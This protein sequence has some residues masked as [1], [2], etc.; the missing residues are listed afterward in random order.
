LLHEKA[1]KKILQAYA[2]W[3]KG[4]KIS[5]EDYLRR[6]RE[7]SLTGAWAKEVADYLISKEERKHVK[8]S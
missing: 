4:L 7:N 3:R 5:W 1:H 6:I 2:F 8:K